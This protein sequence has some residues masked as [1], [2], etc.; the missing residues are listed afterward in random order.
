MQRVNQEN[1][2]IRLLIESSDGDEIERIFEVNGEDGVEDT[3]DSW[4]LQ[5]LDLDRANSDE[6]HKL[7][8]QEILIRALTKTLKRT[9]E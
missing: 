3:R 1:G 4:L 2:S 9:G 8:I 6:A 5:V 7:N